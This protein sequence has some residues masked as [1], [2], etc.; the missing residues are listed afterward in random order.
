MAVCGTGWNG[1][2]GLIREGLPRGH[3]TVAGSGQW[4]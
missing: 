4:D 1:V 2:M 3:A